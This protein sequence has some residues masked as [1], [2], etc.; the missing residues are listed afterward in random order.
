VLVFPPVSIILLEKDMTAVPLEIHSLRFAVLIL[1]RSV[2]GSLTDTEAM[3]LLKSWVRIEQ[4]AVDRIIEWANLAKDVVV[5]D[6]SIRGAGEIY[7]ASVMQD[8]LE[9]IVKLPKV[10]RDLLFC[11]CFEKETGGQ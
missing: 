9:Q 2:L 1:R 5:E 7:A 8:L 4:L 11:L 6:K 10:R 3:L